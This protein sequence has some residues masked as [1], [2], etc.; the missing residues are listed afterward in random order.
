[1]IKVGEFNITEGH[2]YR[3]QGCLY[4]VYQDAK[5]NEYDLD[6]K[7]E[8]EGKVKI[9]RHYHGVSVTDRIYLDK[10]A[11]FFSFYQGVA[12]VFVES[13]DCI[14]QYVFSAVQS[15]TINIRG[16]DEVYSSLDNPKPPKP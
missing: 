8:Y 7:K 16:I 15:K 1:M 6:I 13:V 11:S 4:T 3:I 2:S 5:D 12:E 14:N 9:L 10:S